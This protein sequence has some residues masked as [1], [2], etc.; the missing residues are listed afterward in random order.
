M[1]V[2]NAWLEGEHMSTYIDI[3]HNQMMRYPKNARNRCGA[4]DYEFLVWLIGKLGKSS[5]TALMSYEGF[6]DE[7]KIAWTNIDE[8]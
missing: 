3:I 7:G 4:V 6:F 1:V 2:G 8:A 5:Y